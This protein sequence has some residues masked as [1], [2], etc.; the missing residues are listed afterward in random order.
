MWYFMHGRLEEARQAAVFRPEPFETDPWT[1]TLARFPMPPYAKHLRDVRIVLDAGHGGRADRDGWKR[2][3]TGLRE[4]EVNLRVAQY[5]REFLEAVGA[6]VIMTRTEDVFLDRDDGR[7]L[8]ARAEA[9][10]RWPAD[11]LLSIHHNAGVKNSTSNYTTMYYHGAPDHNLVSVRAA[12][13]LWESLNDALRLEQQLD[14]GVVSDFSL[15]P[16]QGL[17][18]LR[19]ALVPAVLSEASFHS[20]P[21][22]EKRLR[23]PAYNRREAYGLFLG[24]AR[25]AQAGLPRVILVEPTDGRV[26]AGKPI[27]IRLDDGLSRRGSLGMN[28]PQFSADSILAGY[29]GTAL[30]FEFIA[31]KKQIRIEATER[32]SRARGLL[33]VDF[34][35][36]FGQ[37]VVHPWIDLRGGR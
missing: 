6:E 15:Y 36:L 12:R 28:L 27:V 24:L 5:L 14:C 16:D 33:Y 29:E 31:N 13:C 37:H 20:H 19:D 26:E 30:P 35:N 18:L 7:D 10:N 23:D 17:R 8:T 4:A 1:D 2:G 3:P 11:L 25:W 22:E 21:L 9:A 32:M 34:E